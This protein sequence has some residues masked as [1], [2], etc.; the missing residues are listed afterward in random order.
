MF[1]A[2]CCVIKYLFRC[3]HKDLTVLYFCIAGSSSLSYNTP[4]HTD[5]SPRLAVKEGRTPFFLFFFFLSVI[6]YLS[7]S[8]GHLKWGCK[9][10][11]KTPIRANFGVFLETLSATCSHKSHQLL[12]CQKSAH[13]GQT[14]ASEY[15]PLSEARHRRSLIADDKALGRCILCAAKTIQA[16]LLQQIV[17]FRPATWTAQKSSATTEAYIIK[18]LWFCEC[19]WGFFL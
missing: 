19:W 12:T 13:R 1:L 10:K 14:H 6:Y 18:A 3:G 5:P 9:C 15:R 7:A 4:S 17:P 2:V 8:L 16:K 11:T